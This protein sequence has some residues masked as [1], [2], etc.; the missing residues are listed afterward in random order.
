MRR[1]AIGKD[2]DDSTGQLKN[3]SAAVWLNASQAE[4]LASELHGADFTVRQ[5]TEKP[6]VL[7]PH[8]PFI[9]SSL[10][11]EANRKLGFTAQRTMRAAQSL[12]ENGYITYMRTDSTNL[13]GQ[14]IHAARQQISDLYGESFVPDKPRAYSRKVKNAQEAHEAIRPAGSHFRKPQQLRA[15]LQDDAYRIYELI[16]KRTIASQMKDATGQRTQVRFEAPTTKGQAGFSASGKVFD[17][18]GFLR[19]YVE[20]ADDP[21]AELEDQEKVLPLMK[22]GERF[23]AQKVEALQHTTLPPARFTEASLISELE[24][25]GIGRPST[26]A[27]IIQTIQ[28]RGYVWKKD[29]A[30]VPTFTAFAVVQLMERYLEDLIDFDFTARMEDDL[31][32]IADGQQEYV[33]WLHDFYFG[34]QDQERE[35]GSRFRQIGLKT[36]IGQGVADI[37][38]REV[39]SVL[40][41]KT[42]NGEDVSAR[43]GRYGPYVQIGDTD[44]RATI[45]D[46]IPPDELTMEKAMVLIE[47]AS[48]G[49]K[50]LG[51]DPG[52]GKDVYLKV[53]RF[54]P[55]V[56][57]GEPELTEKGTVRRGGKPKMASVWPTLS[58]ETLTL[59]QALMLLSYPKSLGKHPETGEEI[60]AQDGRFGPYIKMGSETRSLGDHDRLA[61]VTLDDA[62]ELLKQPKG[63][64][65]ATQVLA[66][67]GKH[68]K[69]GETIQ[70]K[71][72][73]YGPYV[74]DGVVNATIPKGVDP[75]DITVEKAVEW[76]D[77]R[78]Q[79]MREQGKDPRAK[80]VKKATRTGRKKSTGKKVPRRKSG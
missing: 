46:D 40:I 6:F 45:P 5:I 27:S 22:E 50:I 29:K 74:T 72:G 57:L 58:P 69:S 31:D 77:A 79:K 21:K 30:L 73:R 49:D 24:Q 42:E 2:F 11:Q 14:A 32:A 23:S 60:T 1:I 59:D 18:H 68:P 13:S 34:Q 67:I 26:Y 43:V 28:D 41:G 65:A 44:Q 3:G 17:F 9:T 37:N 66:E 56:Q 48:G 54:G 78:E 20:G 61:A 25:R 33:P 38:P 71:S 12:Y 8:A 64:R 76:L 15:E 19:A 47:Q 7:R 35:N 10:Q 55:Y 70:A 63:R 75:A 52:S 80:K 39:A 4:S 36:L 62:I 53:G 51:R 16:W